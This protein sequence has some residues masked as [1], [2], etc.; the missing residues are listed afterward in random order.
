VIGV[1]SPFIDADSTFLRDLR[2]GLGD[3][4]L[5]EG[6]E[7]AIEYR[8]AEGR[9]NQLPVLADEL[10]RLKVDTI[11]TASAPAIR[12]VQQATLTIPIVM[13]Q[14][15]D[16]V[17]QGFVASL[18]HPGGN[19]TGTSWFGPELSAKRLELMK[20]TFPEIAQ[21]AILREASAGAASVTAVHAAARTLSVVLS[22]FE[23]RD[24]DELPTAFSAMADARLQG[25]EILEGL[26]ISN[27]V[28]SLVALAEGHRL[29][30][31][32]PDSSFVEA[33]GLMSYGPDLS[34]MHRRAAGT[35]EKILKGVRP[36]DIPVQQPTKFEFA[37]NLKTAKALGL[38]I[39][40]TLLQRATVVLD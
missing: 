12:F 26:I 16:A 29:P 21:L 2:Q 20:E 35:I 11:V 25:V 39:P 9:I 36:R 14:V 3:R 38:A 33:G 34:E 13:M 18:A 24:A 40:P 23:V 17:D 15:G 22:I 5:R 6:Q 31:I 19:I 1:L 30:T 7:I 32:F 10:V 27:N 8:S 37:I 4:G 28:R